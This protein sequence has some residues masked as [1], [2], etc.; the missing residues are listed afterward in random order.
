MAATSSRLDL[1]F[2]AQQRNVTRLRLAFPAT[3][4]L[5]DDLVCPPGPLS[6][7]YLSLHSL[8]ATQA[9]TFHAHSSPAPMQIKP[10]PAPTI[11]NQESVHTTLSITRH[12]KEQ[13][14][15]G[16]RTLRSSSRNPN[17]DRQVGQPD[18]L[19][20]KPEVRSMERKKAT[21]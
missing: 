2:E 11:L 19:M 5:A 20:V 16:H 18:Q 14:S 13:P 6:R 8:E 9:K 7:A 17:T 21:I 10:Q 4:W 15:T 3:M 12:T 1:G